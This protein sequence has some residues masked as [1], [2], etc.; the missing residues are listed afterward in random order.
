MKQ[1]IDQLRRQ[2][3]MTITALCLQSPALPVSKSLQT[4]LSFVGH[5][6][7]ILSGSEEE[8]GIG[9]QAEGSREVTI[10]VIL[11]MCYPR[12]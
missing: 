1:T 6:Q 7:T 2:Q 4:C 12:P 11:A 9:C 10:Q 8:G 3:A 5:V